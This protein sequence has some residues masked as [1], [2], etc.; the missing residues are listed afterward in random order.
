MSPQHA[1]PF[2]RRRFLEGLTLAGT[3]GL[4]GLPARRVAA[5]PPPETTT[6]RLLLSRSGICS[7]PY[8]MAE[9]LLQAEGFTDI[10]Y[11]DEGRLSARLRMLASGESDLEYTF[12]GPYLTHLDAGDPI[13]LIAGIHVGC[14]ELFGTEQVRAI[15]DLKGKTVAISD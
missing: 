2:S 14:F 3:A 5:E 12:V 10:H 1:R 13:V 8:V 9:E 6:L 4:L 7:A 15:R 11:I